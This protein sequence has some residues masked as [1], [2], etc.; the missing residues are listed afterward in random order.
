MSYSKSEN[1]L[2]FDIETTGLSA[3][4][5]HITVIGTAFSDSGTVHVKQF[6]CRKPTDEKKILQEFASYIKGF[7]TL[8]HFNGRSFDIPYITAKFR[9]YQIRNT[10]YDMH[11][12]DLYRT[13]RYFSFLTGLRHTKQK[14]VEKYFGFP[15]T[16]TLS[17]ADCTSAYMDYICKGSREALEKL[18]L[19]NR[20]DLE[21]MVYINEYLS[22][23]A[24]V[25]E[26][27]FRLAGI[28]G[29]DD[30]DPLSDETDSLFDGTAS[31]GDTLNIILETEIPFRAPF[32]AVC[33]GSGRGIPFSFSAEGSTAVFSLKACSG[34]MKYFFEDYKDYYYLPQEGRAI[35]KSI[36]QFVDPAFREQAKKETAFEPVKAV[37]YPQCG[38]VIKPQFKSCSDDRTG[39][40]RLEDV[41][42]PEDLKNLIIAAFGE[43]AGK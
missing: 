34:E 18:L 27:R 4:S 31:C 15:R 10:L 16:D 43:A 6:I 12:T 33:E 24:S 39:Y 7:D 9:F 20:E 26:G 37:F 14:D 17:G 28:T 42:D 2:Y 13:A 23:I 35:H 21:G 8:V 11:E 5:S 1:K 36:G 40:F 41:K 32:F 38:S 3:S 30:F 25:A 19:H 22:A 29:N